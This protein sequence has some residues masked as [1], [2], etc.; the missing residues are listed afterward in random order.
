[1]RTRISIILSFTFLASL[2]AAAAGKEPVVSNAWARAT[3][4]VVD[5]GAGYMV[6][7]NTSDQAI[8][9][10]SVETP[11]AR[12]V[13]LHETLAEEGQM[14]MQHLD[15]GLT[16]PAGG[17]VALKPKGPHLMLIDLKGPLVPGDEHPL[18]LEFSNGVAVNTSLEVRSHQPQSAN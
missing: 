12:E 10:T 3:P 11:A 5:K 9:L 8:R 15:K 2:N 18:T 17:T 13:Q 7:G 1:M 4:S 6:I 14:R 16:V